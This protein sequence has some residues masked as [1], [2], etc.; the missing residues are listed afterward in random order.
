MKSAGLLFTFA[1]SASGAPINLDAVTFMGG[2]RLLITASPTGSDGTKQAGQKL[3]LDTGSSTLAFCDPAS[4]TR[5][6]P[7]AGYYSC[8]I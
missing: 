8:N 3:L 6:S 5:S 1:T 7:K 4:R 2:P